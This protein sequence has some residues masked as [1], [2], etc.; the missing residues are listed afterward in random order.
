MPPSR[1]LRVDTG[2]VPDGPAVVPP[3]FG[4]RVF[5]TSGGPRLVAAVELVSPGN[6]DRAEKRTA[7]AAK[8]VA[9]LTA[10]CGVRVR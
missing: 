2:I 6:K 7:V 10:G 4:V 9:N 8:C 1:V 5:E 3:E